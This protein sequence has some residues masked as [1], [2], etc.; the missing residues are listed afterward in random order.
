M[1]KVICRTIKSKLIV[2]Y[3]RRDILLFSVK[4]DNLIILYYI[5]IQDYSPLIEEPAHYIFLYVCSQS[6]YNVCGFSVRE[7]LHVSLLAH[8]IFMWVLE[9]W[10]ICKLLAIGHVICMY[11]I[12]AVSASCSIRTYK[13]MFILKTYVQGLIYRFCYRYLYRYVYAHCF[14]GVLLHLLQG[15]KGLYRCQVETA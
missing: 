4:Q 6:T 14:L 7:M 10:K 8:R 3:L 1:N 15:V 12:L 5:Y 9:F 13:S 11:S 2:P